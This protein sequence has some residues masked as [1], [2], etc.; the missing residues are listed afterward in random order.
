VQA[1]TC[2]HCGRN[3]LWGTLFCAHCG[4]YLRTWFVGWTLYLTLLGVIFAVVVIWLAEF[5]SAQYRQPNS[6][7]WQYLAKPMRA[8]TA[9]LAEE[10]PRGS[11]LRL[12]PHGNYNL[13]IYLSG[14]SFES[15]PPSRRGVFL[16]RLT[17]TWCE[18]L[19]KSAFVPFVQIR[20]LETADE[21][22]TARCPLL[23]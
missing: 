15:V 5:L 10:L 7:E 16:K 13:Q 23:R 14:R 1:L 18:N 19:P 21:L 11:E 20:D 12:E 3:A 6:N 22:A 2:R 17:N 8:V 4:A 9:L